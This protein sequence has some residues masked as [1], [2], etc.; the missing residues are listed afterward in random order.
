M[1]E[2]SFKEINDSKVWKDFEENYHDFETFFQS[3]EWTEFEKSMHKEVFRIGVYRGERVIGVMAVIHIKAKRGNL[4]H[5]RNGPLID[6]NDE[7]VVKACVEYIQKLAGEN[8][9][10]YARIS[11]LI[12]NTKENKKKLQE[13]GFVNC[14]MHDVDAEVTWVMGLDKTEDEIL[15]GM[16]KHTRYYIS[17]AKRDGVS[18][19]KSINPED[20]VKFWPIFLDTVKRQDWKA[21]PYEYVFNEFKIFSDAGKALLILA[22]YTEKFIAGSIFIFHK[23]VA[24]YHHSGSLTE[25]R[26]IPAPYLIQWS[27]IKEAKEKGMKKYNFFGIARTDNPKHPW[28]GLTFFKKGFGG[29]A[30]NHL[31]AQ[32]L[33]IKRRYWLTHVFEFAEKKLRGY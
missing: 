21:Y 9:C 13:Y 8:N 1:S 11:P 26:Q 19:I 18:V 32:D 3:W 27:I 22:K 25:F 2:I 33:P 6:W 23:G 15:A 16:K 14:Q 5:V 28:S 31:H 20:M 24:Y 10:S 17:R 7:E 12:D 30:E 29:A 4:L